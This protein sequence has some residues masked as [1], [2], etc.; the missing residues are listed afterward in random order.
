MNSIDILDYE[1]V[2]NGQALR[3]PMS[4]E[5]IQE[6]LGDARIEDDR[7]YTLYI[8]DDLG[9]VFEGGK[10]SMLWLKKAKGYK[11]E[12]HNITSVR[13]CA[14]EDP[15]YKV[16]VP[17]N[18]YTGNVTFMGKQVENRYF[19]K[20]MGCYQALLKTGEG[21][22]EQAHVGAY[23][24]GEDKD[25][26]YE[27][28]RFLK[29]MMI[30]FKPRRPKSLENYNIEQSGDDCL[31]FDNFNF[32]LAVI[33]ELM[34][35]QEILKPY[36]DI[37]DYMEFK[38]A[39]WNLETEKNVRAAVQFFKDL[40]IPSAYAE[41]ITRISMD[42]GNQIYLNIAP[43]WDGEDARF[44]VDK[45]TAVELKQFPNLKEMELMTTNPEKLKKICEPLG[46]LLIG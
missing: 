42:G 24:Q 43:M 13:V 4:Y 31:T 34:Y 7:L 28:E 35:E 6:K 8:Y 46:I 33:N 3:F 32:K 19:N 36:F 21:E 14:A 5:E 22:F 11:D 17:H 23:V 20:F 39:N 44:D 9:I 27:G 25:P 2:I 38:K 41:K 26:N 30:V 15:R 16:F 10:G 29:P 18:Y 12:K 45:L 40:P 1:I 37:Y